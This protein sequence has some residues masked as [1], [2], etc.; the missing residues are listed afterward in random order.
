MATSKQITELIAATGVN[1]TDQLPLAQSGHSEAARATVQQLAEAVG[2]LNEKGALRELELA[3]SL[4]KNLLAQNLTEKGVPTTPDET[5]I[6]M[7]DKVNNLQTTESTRYIVSGLSTTSSQY[8]YD[9]AGSG[10][11]KVSSVCLL[12]GYTALVADG[13]MYFCN[14]TDDY[15]TFEDFINKAYSSVDLG[16]TAY[17]AILK[18]SPN[19]QY[20]AVCQAREYN[21]VDVYSVD[22]ENH[23][24]TFYKSITLPSNYYTYY[25]VAIN[26]DVSMIAWVNGSSNNGRTYLM[27]VDDTES[28]VQLSS[29]TTYASHAQVTFDTE[30]DCL[31]V[32]AG[33]ASSTSYKY[34]RF[35]YT[36][37]EGV[38]SY[39]AVYVN[40]YG[41]GM[42]YAAKLCPYTNQMLV[43]AS[44]YYFNNYGHICVSAYLV[45]LR[46]AYG[47]NNCNVEIRLNW[48]EVYSSSL[49]GYEVEIGGILDCPVTIEEDRIVYH[50]C[51]PELDII[52][53]K[54]NAQL[55]YEMT[56][57]L[58]MPKP[59]DFFPRTQGTSPN[60]Y[61]KTSVSFFD[62][63]HQHV[64]LGGE[65]NMNNFKIID[66]VPEQVIG[67]VRHC[68]GHDVE[69]YEESYPAS[70]IEKGYYEKNTS[71]IILEE[72]SN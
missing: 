37:T 13:R 19:G 50:M 48:T 30:L 24:F 8:T 14:T 43:K 11:G 17:A 71:K 21:V 2:E 64:F 55:S 31:Y 4:G 40:N 32:F 27:L 47:T 42:S 23:T 3:T 46:N 35:N 53:N 72:E 29:V 62:S 41:S 12:H 38:I 56:G 52:Y 60:Y 18:P 63:K 20:I 67:I 66:V 15:N 28:A 36:V 1:A 16:F 34:A 44:T 39:T 26:N 45:D 70:N 49:S 22:Y 54:A 68:N 61:Y 69:Y 5:L 7:A 57:T 51:V 33:F 10:Y 25:A 59:F 6:S 65:W 9:T 58:S